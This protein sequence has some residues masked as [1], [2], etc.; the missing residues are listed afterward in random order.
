MFPFLIK[1]DSLSWQNEN[2]LH[3]VKSLK[4]H[5]SEAEWRVGFNQ[6]KWNVPVS[7]WI[8][9]GAI[10]LS[11]TSAPASL[12]RS[13]AAIPFHLMMLWSSRPETRDFPHAILGALI[14]QSAP[15]LAYG[16]DT[17]YLFL[18]VLRLAFICFVDIESHVSQANLQH[19]MQSKITLHFWSFCLSLLPSAMITRTGNEPGGGGAQL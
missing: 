10:G 15:C 17:R 12:T 8:R 6:M 5:N 19:I 3:L 13:P 2:V 7:P 16:A 9:M 4:C 14:R 11:I 18:L 1:T